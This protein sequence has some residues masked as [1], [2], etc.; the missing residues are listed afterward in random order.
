[1]DNS[2]RDR[3]P[4]KR[5]RSSFSLESAKQQRPQVQKTAKRTTTRRARSVG[6][7]GCGKD[8]ES[9][10]YSSAG[11]IPGSDSESGSDDGT[12]SDESLVGGRLGKRKQLASCSGG[13]TAKAV[14]IAR[15]GRKETSANV[16][17]P[18]NLG[19]SLSTGGRT[20]GRPRGSV[21]T[22]PKAEDGTSAI[23]RE[24]ALISKE[25]MG[26]RAPRFTTCGWQKRQR[27]NF[28]LYGVQPK[29]ATL[30]QRLAARRWKW[31]QH[32]SL[33]L[34]SQLRIIYEMRDA[35]NEARK[36]SIIRLAILLKNATRE[37]ECLCKT[38]QAIYKDLDSKIR[39][40]KEMEWRG[41]CI[42]RAIPGV[43]SLVESFLKRAEELPPFPGDGADKEGSDAKF[44]RLV[45]A[46]TSSPPLAAPPQKSVV[47]GLAP[48]KPTMPGNS[49][50]SYAHLMSTLPRTGFSSVIGACS[51]GPMPLPNFSQSSATAFP[52][53]PPPF[54]SVY[55]GMHPVG[56][57]SGFYGIP[58]GHG[59]GY[60]AV[61]AGVGGGVQTFSGGQAFPGGVLPPP[62]GVL[63]FPASVLPFPGG[64]FA[65][66]CLGPVLPPLRQEHAPVFESEEPAPFPELG[67]TVCDPS[68]LLDLGA[69][70][71]DAHTELDSR[72]HLFDFGDPFQSLFE[73]GAQDVRDFLSGSM[74]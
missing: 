15:M 8:S 49:T 57:S 48:V 67:E 2:L 72:G 51:S 70:P 36:T 61:P 23:E 65:P 39:E 45:E 35:D 13:K 59:T 58:G 7:S 16:G 32:L 14:K 46:A 56:M 42:T 44:I 3:H 12:E 4:P 26:E 68:L 21:N 37:G 31:T 20:R 64:S 1:M 25:I 38:Q 63:P 53:P 69:V 24:Q 11:F 34:N 66:T 33:V 40:M 6:A 5:Y 73:A 17:C 43:R 10:G 9:G 60:L 74:L 55:L 30:A 41:V 62:V 52:P 28:K 50:P 27:L 71:S 47:G 19:E 18:D 22:Q 54:G 29:E